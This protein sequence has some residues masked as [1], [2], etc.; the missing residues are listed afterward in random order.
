MKTVILKSMMAVLLP[1]SVWAQ[2]S[3]TSNKANYF[4]DNA[5]WSYDKGTK[6]LTISPNSGEGST[7]QSWDMFSSI[8]VF[9]SDDAVNKLRH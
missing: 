1:V 5:V 2:T 9:A 6:A 4:G 8:R 3:V 7:Q